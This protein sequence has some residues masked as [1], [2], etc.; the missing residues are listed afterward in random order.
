MLLLVALCSC[1][2]CGDDTAKKEVDAG[3]PSTNPDGLRKLAF[4]SSK[5]EL[6][7][8]EITLSPDGREV[9]SCY[10]EGQVVFFDADS[11][12][13][14][15]RVDL[16]LP[17]GKPPVGYCLISVVGNHAYAYY[18]VESLVA[19]NEEHRCLFKVNILDRGLEAVWEIDEKHYDLNAFG[20]AGDSF[21]GVLPTSEQQTALAAI[22]LEKNHPKDDPDPGI[23]P[24]FVDLSTGAFSRKKVAT[25]ANL[26]SQR[27][28]T[29]FGS[30]IVGT[31]WLHGPEYPFDFIADTKSGSLVRLSSE[32]FSQF[33]KV[34]EKTRRLLNGGLPSE[35][36]KVYDLDSGKELLSFP[37]PASGFN[38]DVL[39]LPGRDLAAI[40]QEINTEPLTYVTL[41]STKTG[42]KLASAWLPDEASFAAA[43]T[44]DGRRLFV[45]SHNHLFSVE[46]PPDL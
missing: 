34:D 33:F 21:A 1:Q 35:G 27:L 32:A 10:G 17:N 22:G 40:I 31:A 16:S 3:S 46:V 5:T 15:K 37:T 13:V 8:P 24:L 42:T 9:I 36:F 4:K 41:V 12:T 43:V 2:A 14:K 28:Y 18:V 11:L 45:G 30:K 7:F 25:V 39:L 6:A 20:V 38:N 29:A 44:S 26:E 19:G 23:R